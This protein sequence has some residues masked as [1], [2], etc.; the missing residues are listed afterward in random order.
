M[1][2]KYIPNG[3][4]ATEST[5]VPFD[6]T[7]H[8]FSIYYNSIDKSHILNIQKYLMT[9]NKTISSLFI[10]LLSFSSSLATKCQF[11][12][13]ELCMV[14]PTLIHMNTVELKY[15]PFVINID[16]CT[17]S[18]N[19]LPPKICVLKETKE[20]YITALDVITNKKEAKLMTKHISCD[21]KCKFN[22]TTCNSNQKWNNKTYQYECKNNHKSKTDYS[23]NFS[24]CI[25]GNSKHLKSIFDTLVTECDEII[26]A[27]DIASTKK[28]NS[29]ATNVIS[30]ASI[31][32]H[33]KKVK[34]CYIS[35]KVLLVI[36]LLLI[37]FIIC[38]Y[39]A[40]Q[41]GTI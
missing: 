37:I 6:G 20:I 7:V 33:S 24:T 31:I 19:V 27:M 11:L 28:T 3:F 8:D 2:R 34:D 15:Y 18:C 39:Y 13:D 38:Y 22:N 5:E 1:S 21:C 25:C 10:V 23:W 29:I 14:R 36:I 41:K 40:K 16:K 9:K 26:I 35:H 32:C 4:S 12:N 30:T 17:G